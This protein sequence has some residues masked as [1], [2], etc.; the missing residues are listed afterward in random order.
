MNGL[1]RWARWEFGR[2]IEVTGFIKFIIAERIVKGSVLFLGGIALIVL[3]ETHTVHQIAVQLQDQ[4]NLDAGKGWWSR[5]VEG[6]VIKF[7]FLSTGKQVLIATGAMLYGALE[8]F[9]AVGLLLRRRWAEYLVLV[10]TAAF[11]PLEID[12]VLRHATPVKVAALLINIAIVAYLVWR[13][14]LFI[15]RPGVEPVADD[16][17]PEA[18]AG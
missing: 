10:A 14:R 11:L 18:A 8:L 9:E 17:K 1:L 7:G 4:L 3:G 12:E 15:E 6:I 13:K 5:L 2:P 16:T